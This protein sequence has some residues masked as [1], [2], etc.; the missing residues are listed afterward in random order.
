MMGEQAGA[1][2]LRWQWC[3]VHGGA[4]SSTLAK[5]EPRGRDIGHGGWSG[6]EWM[7]AV[8]RTNAA[9]LLAAKEMAVKAA[10]QLEHGTKLL[11]LVTVADAPGR[12]PSGL[13]QLRRHATGGYRYA[14]HVDW[15]EAWRCGEPVTAAT[16][17]RSVRALMA[18]IADRVATATPAAV[19]LNGA[20][21]A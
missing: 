18:Q 20:R 17:P 21:N 5:V 10:S 13:R 4:A 14:W 2:H 8:C 3:P 6:V 15:V 11:G 12:L 9:G 19:L 16:T 7:V 1:E